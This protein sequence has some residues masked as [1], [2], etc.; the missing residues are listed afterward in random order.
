MRTVRGTAYAPH[1]GRFCYLRRGQG[2]G[3]R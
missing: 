2:Q 1:M 3:E